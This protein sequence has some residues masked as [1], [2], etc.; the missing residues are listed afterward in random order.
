MTDIEHSQRSFY[1]CILGVPKEEKQLNG[2][3]QILK[4][5]NLKKFFWSKKIIIIHIEKHTMYLEKLT[6]NDQHQNFF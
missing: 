5:Y 3:E 2:T 1:I 4:A 6:Q